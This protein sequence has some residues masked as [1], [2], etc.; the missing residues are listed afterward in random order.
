MS[1]SALEF[2]DQPKEQHDHDDCSQAKGG[3]TSPFIVLKTEKEVIKMNTTTKTTNQHKRKLKIIH[4]IT[5][6]LLAL[7]LV[8]MTLYPALSVKASDDD[9]TSAG[10]GSTVGSSTGNNEKS[11]KTIISY[12]SGSNE[13]VRTVTF[14]L[15]GAGHFNV[16]TV[17]K[18]DNINTSIHVDV[19]IFSDAP[20][21]CSYSGEDTKNGKPLTGVTPLSG[22]TNASKTSNFGS[23]NC[24]N[25][26]VSLG[27]YSTGSNLSLSSPNVVAYTG[28]VDDDD[29]ANGLDLTKDDWKDPDEN[30][31]V[32]NKDLDFASISADYR[33]KYTIEKNKEGKFEFITP[34]DAGIQFDWINRKD[35]DGAYVK[36]TIYGEY[37]D[38]FWGVSSTKTYVTLTCPRKNDLSYLCRQKEMIALAK[39][40][41]NGSKGWGFP[42]NY[43]YVQAFANINGTL[44]RSRIYKFNADLV[45]DYGNADDKDDEWIP[46]ITG[47]DSMPEEYVPDPDDVDPEKKE[48]YPD[49]DDDTIIDTP[50]DDDD[51]VINDDTSYLEAFKQFIN[52]MKQGISYLGDFPLLV[53]SV[54]SFIPPVFLVFIG[55]GFAVA[56]I[57]RFL[58]R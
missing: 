22:S 41:C 26:T 45:S 56:L 14:T 36:F 37:N 11:F 1:V 5:A 42:V 8:T 33:V 15:T 21:S 44:C 17:K 28:A 24:Y 2:S 20:F 18:I 39:E 58:G 25:A 54:F 3:K 19:Y 4:R 6:L 40:K 47:G 35:I 34:D 46:E 32:Y 27:S 31:A 48:P 50:I 10:A 43:I 9:W 29:L 30:S 38:S 51:V 52:V 16:R 53:S 23:L 55:A 12:M 7:L 49:N 13:I 57:L